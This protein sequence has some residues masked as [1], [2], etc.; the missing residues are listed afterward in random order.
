MASWLDILTGGNK[1]SIQELETKFFQSVGNLPPDKQ[2]YANI[3]GIAAEQKLP[4]PPKAAEYWLKQYDAHRKRI[5]EDLPGQP[6]GT[7]P[8]D[9]PLARKV[10]DVAGLD[11]LQAAPIQSPLGMQGDLPMTIQDLISSLPSDYQ[12]PSPVQGQQPELSVFGPQALG[13]LPQQTTQPY[14]ASDIIEKVMAASTRPA[15][16]TQ[17]PTGTENITYITDPITGRPKEQFATSPRQILTPEQEAFSKLSPEEQKG[18]LMKSLVNID[19]RQPPTTNV[20]ETITGALNTLEQLDIM[21]SYVGES[22][23]L[24]GLWTTFGAWAG[25]NE[26]AIKFN[27]AVNNVLLSTQSIIKGIPSN[28][29]AGLIKNVTAALYLPQETNKQRIKTTRQ[30]TKNLLY[31]AIA[32][33]KSTKQAL[34]SEIIAQAKAF[35]IDVNNVPKWDGKGDPLLKGKVPVEVRIN[36]KTGKK[37]IKYADGTLEY[38]D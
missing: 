14:I 23:R 34:P 31:N 15:G 22:G 36:P 12:L 17:I 32:F 10:K 37:M 25:T 35:G 20:Q 6:T 24:K 29:D 1:P 19:M 11:Y 8:L 4:N 13:E 28:Y 21:E 18:Q 30:I 2:N 26:D 33:H 38:A 7:T 27:T 5:K 9:V 16:I 3:V